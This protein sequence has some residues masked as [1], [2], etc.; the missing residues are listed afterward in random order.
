MLILSRENV[1]ECFNMKDAVL[2]TKEAMR[3]YS[4]GQS[5]VPLRVNLPVAESNGQ[6][7][8]MPAYAVGEEG[9]LGVKIVSSYPDN[10]AKGLPTIPATMVVL[11]PETGIV[12]AIIDGTYLTQLRTGAIQGAATEEMSR[13]DAKIAALIGTGGQAKSQLEAMLTVRD[14]TEVRIFDINLESAVKFANEMTEVFAAFKATFIPCKAVS[15]AVKGADIITTVTTSKQAT[16]AAE[17]VKAGAHVNGVGAYTP[18][19]KE[20]PSELIQR[21]DS[22]IFD[23]WDAVMAEAGD[24]IDPLKNGLVTEA[25]Y[26]GEFGQLLLGDIKGRQSAEDITVFK[27]VGSAVLDVVTA[28]LIVNKA[29]ELG[30]GKEISI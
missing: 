1:E 29:R 9:Y 8:Y 25:D 19:M 14:L 11:N 2:A 20:V 16:F 24:F 28:Q 30:I 26:D 3:L 10:M 12:D 5:I 13:E 21:A 22:I 27:S 7:L 4:K 6:S 18:E 15:D 17:D 23:T